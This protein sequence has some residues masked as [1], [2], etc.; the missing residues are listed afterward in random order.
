M[1]TSDSVKFSYEMASDIQIFDIKKIIRLRK[2]PAAADAG[3]ADLPTAPPAADYFPTGSA[4]EGHDDV[5]E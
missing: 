4:A 3:T 5:G 2:N 1:D